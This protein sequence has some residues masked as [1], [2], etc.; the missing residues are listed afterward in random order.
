MKNITCANDI[1][2]N[3]LKKGDQ[4]LESNYYIMTVYKIGEIYNRGYNTYA[5]DVE[6]WVR[7]KTGRN[8]DNQI[9]AIHLDLD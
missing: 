1:D 8:L 3:N 9:K 2:L 5:R 4:F 7:T 6:F